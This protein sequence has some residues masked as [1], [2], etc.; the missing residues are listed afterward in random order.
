MIGL[1][2]GEVTAAVGGRL[3]GA[4]PGHLVDGSVVIDSRVAGPGSLFVAVV[5]EHVDGHDFAAPAIRRGA[6]AVLAARPVGAP[7]VLVEDTTL[8]LGRLAAHLRSRLGGLHTVGVTGS[9]GKTSTKDLLAHLLA[10]DG[11][12]VA[13]AGS[14]NNELGVPLTVL[15]SDR[16]TRHLV[17]EMGARGDGHIRYLCE[18]ARPDTGLVLNVGTAHVGE[19]GSR[20]AIARTKGELVEALPGDGVAVLNADDPLVLAMAERTQAAVTTFGVTTE[21][22]VRVTDL[23]LDESGCPSFVLATPGGAAPVEMRLLGAHQANNAAAAAA[24]ALAAGIGLGTVARALG[25]ATPASRWRMERRVRPDGVVVVNDAYNA[26]P[27]AMRSALRT[28]AALGRAPGAGRTVAVLGEMRELG[29][30]ADDEHRAVGRLAAE[31]GVDRLVVVGAGAEQLHRGAAD[32]DVWAGGSVRVPD[33]DAALAAL[34]GYLRPGDVVLVKASRAAGLERVAEGLV[35]DP[36]RGDTPGAGAD[37]PDR[38]TTSGG[39]PD[40]EGKPRR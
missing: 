1:T 14:L 36:T 26:S 20:E 24:V 8:A 37:P 23:E 11:P 13:P 6:V 31:L 32:A 7:Y 40:P 2:L 4:D 29:A 30:V 18:I 38:D 25:T 3:D 33:V 9:Q 19:F 21:A 34:E 10:E 17:V 28:L 15:R 16:Q 39:R 35:A 27:D 22:D 12:V 5:G